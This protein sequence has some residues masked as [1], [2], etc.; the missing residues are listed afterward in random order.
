MMQAN[1]G[2]NDLRSAV[3]VLRD[4]TAHTGPTRLWRGMTVT[5][6]GC[7]PAHAAYFTVYESM[8]TWL[9]VNEPGHHPLE[10]ATCGAS[11]TMLHDVVMTPM[12]VVK[13]RLQ[14]GY[15]SGVSDCIRRIAAEEGL[16]GFLRSYPTTLG[17][18]I[19]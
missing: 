9:H 6:A 7:I 13:Q 10:A 16:R 17:M 5:M 8:K 15:Y 3:R 19:P 14:L 12:D 18:N 11:A 4:V 2:K 1:R